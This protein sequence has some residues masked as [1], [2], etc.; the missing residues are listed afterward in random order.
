MKIN[1]KD[2][3][4]DL[5]NVLFAN[6]VPVCS[7]KMIKKH[8][9]R[10]VLKENERYDAV[11]HCRYVDE[12]LRD[13][14]WSYSDDFL[15]KNKIDFVAHDDIPYPCGE[16]DDIYAKLKKR[17]MFLP[18]QR[19]DGVSTSDVVA[20]IVRD[21]DIYVRRNLARG[22]SAKE[23]NVSFL[24][25]KKIKLQEKVDR[26]KNK[27]KNLIDVIGETTDDVL[28]K[29]EEKSK[30]VIDHFVMFFFRKPLKILSNSKRKL[31]NAIGSD[32]SSSSSP[33]TS[34]DDDD[35]IPSKK[36]RIV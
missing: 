7:D 33:S 27:G 21:Y 30:E 4:N 10:T 24:K 26:L 25:E 34:D 17:G 19:T 15:E 36:R 1:R 13:A 18:T 9:G 29:W 12:V 35:E 22:Y 6:I 5:V 14:P 16:V 2:I 3:R 31:M 23:L 20:R 32:V 28:S 11:R 8:K